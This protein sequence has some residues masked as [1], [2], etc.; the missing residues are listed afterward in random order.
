MNNL[1]GCVILEDTTLSVPEIM[2]NE[3]GYIRF[4]TCLQ[5][6][7]NKNRNDR[8][9]KGYNLK[10]SL[11]TDNLKEKIRTKNFVGE[12]GH[13]L[14]DDIQRQSRIVSDNISHIITDISFDDNKNL[15]N[16]VVETYNGFKGPDMK[17]AIK[18]GVEVAFSLRAIGNARKD[19]SGL[20]VVDGPIL[21]IS[22]DWVLFPSHKE[23]YIKT[24]R[25]QGIENKVSLKTIP[26]NDIYMGKTTVQE[27]FK[28]LEFD[29]SEMIN[30][31]S[32]SDNVQC[33]A[34][35]MNVPL[36]EESINILSAHEV[37]LK[38]DNEVVKVFIEENL[39][40]DIDKYLIK[41]KK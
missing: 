33:L 29:M 22:Y 11:T 23:A 5:S 38:S 13:P 28:L 26:N 2:S 35:S 7:D 31:L 25:N 8:I 40:K 32:K 30:L 9:Y 14:S 20:A 37:Y 17:G 4:N 36:N 3:E 6:Y 41:L 24:A 27:D 39:N 15:V 21:V 18:Q 34:E 16:G 12:A 10:E 19:A 1:V